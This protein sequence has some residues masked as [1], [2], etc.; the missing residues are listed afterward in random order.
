MSALRLMRQ[1]MESTPL[2][3]CCTEIHAVELHEIPGC[4]CLYLILYCSWLP[5]CVGDAEADARLRLC[6]VKSS[7]S[8]MTPD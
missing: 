6:G 2:L 3:V 8:G 1:Q 5:V 4:C 7:Q